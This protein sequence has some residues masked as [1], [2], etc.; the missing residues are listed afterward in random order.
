MRN[1]LRSAVLLAAFAAIGIG[2]A[3]PARVAWTRSSSST[4]IA[5]DAAHAGLVNA[6]GQFVIAGASKQNDGSFKGNI[7]I[8]ARN[9]ALLDSVEVSPP[10]GGSLRFHKIIVWDGFYFA[11]GEAVPTGSQDSQLYVGKFDANLNLVAQHMQAITP[12]GGRELPTDVA[13]D[14]NGRLYICAIGEKGTA[15]ESA[16][17][18]TDIIISSFSL[19]FPRVESPVFF[20]PEITTNGIIAILIGLFTNSGPRLQSYTPGGTL[21]FSWG[22]SIPTGQ[23]TNS[24]VLQDILISSYA[25]VGTGWTEPTQTGFRSYGRVSRIDLNTGQE[26]AFYQ[27]PYADGQ[28]I[29]SPRDAASGQ[30]TGKRVNFLFD[31]GNRARIYSFDAGITAE[32]DWISPV[33]SAF[34]AGLIVDQYDESFMSLCTNEVLKVCKLNLNND[35]RYAFGAKQSGLLLPYMEASNIYEPT[36][37][38]TLSLRTDLDTMQLV[39]I[40]QA[41]VAVTD[42]VFQPK[43]GKLFRP[44]NSVLSNDRFGGG[45]GV[46]ITQQPAHGTVTMGANGFFNYTSAPGY[47]GPDSF[48]YTLTK[49]GL[50]SSTATVNLNVKP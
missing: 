11:V 45:A 9:R 20:K 19:N 29:V 38:D 8:F 21:N 26:S 15:Y 49:T 6:N 37:G 31:Q 39:C 17:T 40:Q 5:M 10:G 30:A 22:A 48:K 42:G 3:Q 50:N 23:A 36:S 24:I 32:D 47:V 1:T 35:L 18:F 7:S 14:G 33:D 12:S 46:T 34:S 16:I 27:T 2:S 41:P 28:G 43:S 4:D 44:A 13:L 25:Y